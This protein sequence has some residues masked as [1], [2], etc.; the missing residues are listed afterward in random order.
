MKLLQFQ[1][2]KIALKISL[3]LPQP[4]SASKELEQKDFLR[5]LVAKTPH[6]QCRLPRFDP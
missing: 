3:F 1:L 6:S 5:G 2:E 4:H